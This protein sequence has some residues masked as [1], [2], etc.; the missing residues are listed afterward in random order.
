LNRLI[1]FF[2]VMEDIGQ[3]LRLQQRNDDNI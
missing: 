2:N 1:Q 3:D